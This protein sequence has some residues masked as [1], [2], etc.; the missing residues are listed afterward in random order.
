MLV[1]VVS[2]FKVDNK[3]QPIT[4]KKKVSP[5]ANTKAKVNGKR[6]EV[7]VNLNDNGYDSMDNGYSKF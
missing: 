2:F 1:E 7:I 3:V 4:V 6:N 5:S